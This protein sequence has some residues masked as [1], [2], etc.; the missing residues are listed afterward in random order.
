VTQNSSSQVSNKLVYTIIGVLIGA[1]VAL[2][3]AKT[4]NPGLIGVGAV[5][6]MLLGKVLDRRFNKDI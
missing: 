3:F 6:G 4:G 5:L 2:V 1:V